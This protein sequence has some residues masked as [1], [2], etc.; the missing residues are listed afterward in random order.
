MRL[1]IP[2]R[3]RWSDLDAYGHVNNVQILR[4]LEEARVQ[5]F[6]ATDE[7]GIQLKTSESGE[8]GDRTSIEGTTMAVI[9]ADLG[10]ATLSL[11]AHQEVEYL[12]PIPFLRQ[13]LDLHLWISRLGGASL[14]LCYEVW[15]PEGV[16]PA[17]LFT[18][19]STTLVLVDAATQRPRRITDEERAAWQ[20]Y[21]DEPVVF[22]K[23]R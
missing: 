22:N 19:A 8:T 11:V 7:P 3:L 23:R 18:R 2:T 14:E 12:A 13:P 9:N 17:T 20:P 6:W 15:S 1:H 4:L 10:S 21:V 5:A 16:V